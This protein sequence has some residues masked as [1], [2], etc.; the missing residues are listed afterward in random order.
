MLSIECP[1]GWKEEY[2]AMK[3]VVDL[4]YTIEE[5]MPVYPGT[6][7]PIL[8]QGSTYLEDGFKETLLTMY[9]HTGTHMDAPHHLFAERTTLDTMPASHFVGRAFVCDC[10]NKGERERISMTDLAAYLPQLEQAEYLLL[11]TGWS[12]YWGTEA[13][14]G[15]YPCVDVTVLDYLTRTGK[16]GIGLDTIGL[17]P[18]ADVQ[19]QGHKR[20]LKEHDIVVIENLANLE[21]LCNQSF[22]LF[23]LPL[24]FAQADGAPIRAVAY[25]DQA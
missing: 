20:L 9:S 13:Y 14:F 12:Q 16:K 15:A 25:L 8:A 7:P 19:L 6:Q 3:Q 11:Y 17:D 5:T 21:G 23:A 2:T 10:S 18:I 4:T 24:K 22:T 1:K